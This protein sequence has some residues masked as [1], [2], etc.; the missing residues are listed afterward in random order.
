MRGRP[1]LGGRWLE[2]TREEVH[3]DDLKNPAYRKGRRNLAPAEKPEPLRPP[4]TTDERRSRYA[5]QVAR[6]EFGRF[7]WNDELGRRM[8]RE[9]ERSRR[10]L[11]EGAQ[12]RRRRSDG[13]G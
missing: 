8:E 13:A 3:I 7:Y 4:P 6:A 2:P 11:R 12:K 1:P 10:L 5:T 9:L